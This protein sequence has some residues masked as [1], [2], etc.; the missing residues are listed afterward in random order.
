MRQEA[1]DAVRNYLNFLA[2][3]PSESF[4]TQNTEHLATKTDPIEKLKLLQ[5][6]QEERDGSHLRSEFLEHAVEWAYEEDITP[7]MF[8]ELGVDPEDLIEAGFNLA[9]RTTRTYV[10]SSEVAIFILEHYDEG[11]AFTKREIAEATGASP[12]T[13]NNVCKRLSESGDISDPVYGDGGSGGRALVW[14]RL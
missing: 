3:G 1:E 8:I 5:V 11:E 13:V 6:I 14:T 7:E 10:S 4:I 2:H 12:G 9:T